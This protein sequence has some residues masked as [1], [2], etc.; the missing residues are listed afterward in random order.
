[1]D[2]I[3]DL[4]LSDAPEFK[5]GPSVEAQDIYND[6]TLSVIEHLKRAHKE[7]QRGYSCQ[8]CSDEIMS[9]ILISE[10]K[11]IELYKREFNIED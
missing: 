11:F 3:N 4:D 6:I 8:L 5:H 9:Q 1:M 10:D 7:Y 2:I